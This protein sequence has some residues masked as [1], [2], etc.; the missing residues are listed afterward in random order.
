[1]L[2]ITTNTIKFIF[3][4]FIGDFNLSTTPS[5]ISELKYLLQY[6]ET[7]TKNMKNKCQ[8]VIMTNNIIRK[9]P[10]LL[11]H[12]SLTMGGRMEGHFL[13]SLRYKPYPPLNVLVARIYMFFITIK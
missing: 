6:N 1:M 13:M 2:L 8:N 10:P 5:T 7:Y 11:N 12:T 3:C 9:S 4:T